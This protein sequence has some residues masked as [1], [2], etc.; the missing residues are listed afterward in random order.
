[1]IVM[2]SLSLSGGQKQRI[3]I[4]R[5]IVRNP[6]ILLLDEGTVLSSLLLHIYVLRLPLTV[7]FSHFCL[8]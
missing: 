5:A 4:A 1:M 3:G 2:F 6:K 7:W 8:G